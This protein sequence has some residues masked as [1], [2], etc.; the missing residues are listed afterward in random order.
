MFELRLW[1]P[2]NIH[3]GASAQCPARG[4]SCLPDII[5]RP[6]EH[7]SSP[8]S[9]AL[10]GCSCSKAICFNLFARTADCAIA[11]ERSLWRAHSPFR[12]AEQQVSLRTILEA[13]NLEPAN[14][15]LTILISW[16]LANANCVLH[17]FA[18]S[19]SRNEFWNIGQTA[20]E[21]HLRKRSGGRRRECARSARDL[22]SQGLHFDSSW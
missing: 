22:E 13:R 2:R 15:S 9:S 21:L 10:S 1:P 4:M 18:T 6:T 16:T 19:R 7:A 11:G 14:T 3:D 5:E 17:D 8:S 12:Q 20:N